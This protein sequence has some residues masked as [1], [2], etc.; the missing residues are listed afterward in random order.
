M[1]VKTL[2]ITPLPAPYAHSAVDFGVEI[3]GLNVENLSNSDF[4][5]I[6]NALY[7]SHVVVIRNQAGVS[8]RAQYELTKRFDSISSPVPSS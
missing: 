4:E 5:A 1:A 6:R 2:Q 7:T 8:P 3:N